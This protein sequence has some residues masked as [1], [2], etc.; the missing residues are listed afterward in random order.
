M[1]SKEAQNSVLIFLMKKLEEGNKEYINVT[2]QI[3]A[4][5][6]FKN[7]RSA[8][9]CLTEMGYIECDK[10][11]EGNVGFFCKITRDG[12]KYYQENLESTIK[13]KKVKKTFNEKM[14]D[15]IS[16]VENAK[17]IIV[18]VVTIV[19][20]V[21]GVSIK[22]I[23]QTVPSLAPIL[24]DSEI[25]EENTENL[26]EH[27]D[28]EEPHEEENH[29]P[30][31]EE[32]SLAEMNNQEIENF[33]LEFPEHELE[34]F[35]FNL[36]EEEYEF[37][38]KKFIENDNKV[39]NLKQKQQTLIKRVSEK[40]TPPRMK[41]KMQRDLDKINIEIENRKQIN[42]KIKNNV[43]IEK[44]SNTKNF[45]SNNPEFH[46]EIKE[47][48][49]HFFWEPAPKEKFAF[50]KLVFSPDNENPIYPEDEMIFVGETQEETEFF[51]PLEDESK[52]EGF[53]AICHIYQGFYDNEEDPAFRSCSQGF[54]IKK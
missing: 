13:E 9:Y 26:E 51:F 47:K 20:L 2:E 32:I 3:E 43:N 40:E 45:N 17:A 18:T 46:F 4:E 33:I 35:I 16:L 11:K 42:D 29:D 44:L 38:H 24:E 8:V 54:F 5:I 27:F 49:F 10:N 22:K 25:I 41:E 31:L 36:P 7:L 14:K 53:W 15:I 39:K 1:N 50:Y 30:D 52:K 6:S 48:G 12:I 23:I 34:N 28:E 21:F 19:A 37:I